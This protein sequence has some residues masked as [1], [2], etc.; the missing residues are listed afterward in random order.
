[1]ISSKVKRS[2]SKKR[3]LECN[4]RFGYGKITS[5]WHGWTQQNWNVLDLI[6]DHQVV[7]GFQKTLDIGS[8]SMHIPHG[9]FQTEMIKP[10]WDI[11][12]ILKA[13]YKIFD[14]SPAHWDVFPKYFQ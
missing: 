12:N 9:V 3:N 2:Q 1:M 14:E 13:L 4:Q 10:E 8:C 6:N 7:N 5:P 11:G